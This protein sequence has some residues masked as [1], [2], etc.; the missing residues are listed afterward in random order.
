MFRNNPVLKSSGRI[1]FPYLLL[2][3]KVLVFSPGIIVLMMLLS[4]FF[5]LPLT[6]LF[7]CFRFV[8]SVALGGMMYVFP[9]SDFRVLDKV[10]LLAC[11]ALA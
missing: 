8:F 4:S 6:C 9:C 1:L 2:S 10:K 3:A 11:N 5:S 7:E